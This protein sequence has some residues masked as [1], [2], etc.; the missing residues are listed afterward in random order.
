MKLHQFEDVVANGALSDWLADCL[1]A[2]A[3]LGTKSILEDD[4]V[5]LDVMPNT[6]ENESGLISAAA[7]L[8]VSPPLED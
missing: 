3:A 7:S 4:G 2:C 5:L 8:G 6:Y 1:F